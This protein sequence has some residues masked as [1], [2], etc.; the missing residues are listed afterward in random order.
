MLL[1]EID[2]FILECELIEALDVHALRQRKYIDP[3]TGKRWRVA[4]KAKKLRAIASYEAKVNRVPI[5]QIWITFSEVP[6]L[7]QRMIINPNKSTPV[8]IFGYPISFAIEKLEKTGSLP[9]MDRRYIH[10][11]KNLK[12]HLEVGKKDNFGDDLKKTVDFKKHVNK[13]ARNNSREKLQEIY[14]NRF[15]RISEVVNKISIEYGKY[16]VVS[17]FF[18]RM[19]NFISMIPQTGDVDIEQLFA[20]KVDFPEYDNIRSKIYNFLVGP[21][22]STFPEVDEKTLSATVNPQY[23]KKVE[24]NI[25]N[26]LKLELGNPQ[27]KI[28]LEKVFFLLSL[29]HEYDHLDDYCDFIIKNKILSNP[30]VNAEIKELLDEMKAFIKRNENISTSTDYSRLPY[31]KRLVALSDKYELDL[32]NAIEKAM[33]GSHNSGKVPSTPNQFL[34]R[35]TQALAHQHNNNS[36]HPVQH[37]WRVFWNSFLREVG[38]S[39]VADTKESGYVHESEPTQGVLMNPKDI[40]HIDTIDQKNDTGGSHRKENESSLK[41]KESIGRANILR[42]IATAMKQYHYT[43]SE[44]PNSWGKAL[45][46]VVKLLTN[47]IRL[48][49]DYANNKDKQL[50][51]YIEQIK[52]DI[53]RFI[54]MMKRTLERIPL[55]INDPYEQNIQKSILYF[56]QLASG[57]LKDEQTTTTRINTGNFTNAQ[58][59]TGEDLPY[60]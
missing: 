7:G 29:N 30:E 40:V 8:G 53:R 34:Y 15:E 57:F 17:K 4:D 3:G 27:Q 49:A 55:D 45:V 37:D 5:G 1:D 9:F 43:F 50:K 16:D 58:T 59:W 2:D 26:K 20:S 31:G 33:S 35:V 14:N 10:I 60:W 6:K 56:Y 11:F 32:S 21:Y 42:G 24:S 47:M 22:G 18:K 12:P 41:N 23:V 44:A 19:F 54:D 51:Q 28:S 46:Q 39:V 25:P 52:G 48:K 13:F 38:I 36:V